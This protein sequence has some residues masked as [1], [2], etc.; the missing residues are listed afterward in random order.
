[1]LAFFG[2]ART[3]LARPIAP[4]AIPSPYRQL[5]VHNGHMTEVL[6]AHHGASVDVHPFSIHRKGEI[7]GR[8]L[9]LS[10]R[11]TGE[12]V[13][14]GL[15]IFN[16]QSVAPMVREEILAARIPLGRILINHRVLREVT[17]EAY[18]HI[19][20]DDPLAARFGLAEPRDV[21]GRLATI[22]CDGA[23]AVD[24][25]EIVRP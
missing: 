5:L 12:I 1:M 4:A 21:Y 16:L 25:L 15:M 9:D 6:E 17:S 3:P 11:S 23:P 8:K 7:Y 18:F 14:T 20:A 19:S 10:C 13:M 2:D 22:F 24:L